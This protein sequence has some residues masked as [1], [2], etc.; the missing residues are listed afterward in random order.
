M[1][2]FSVFIPLFG[3]LLGGLVAWVFYLIGKK[4]EEER[5][6]AVKRSEIWNQLKSIEGSR[7]FFEL[8]V[9]YL[10]ILES[11]HSLIDLEIFQG[12]VFK[13]AS[14]YHQMERAKKVSKIQ[15]ILGLSNGFSQTELK[16]AYRVW[17]M[18]NHPD[19]NKDTDVTLVQE[20][21]QWYEAK[22]I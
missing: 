17:M 7:Y 6:K 11:K 21:Q 4:I 14:N 8:S 5:L 22:K 2:K 13:F 12:L 3:I 20:V 15:G 19:K 10:L 16:K 1:T 9:E 18:R